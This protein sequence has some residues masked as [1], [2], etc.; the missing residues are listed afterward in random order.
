MFC[1]DTVTIFCLMLLKEDDAVAASYREMAGIYRGELKVGLKFNP[2]GAGSNANGT[3]VIDI[4]QAKSL[5]AMNANGTNSVVKLYL[6]PNRKSSGKRKTGVIKHSL[7]P[8][9]EEKFTFEDVTVDELSYAKALEVSV[10][11][12]EKISHTFIGGLRIGPAPGSGGKQYDWMDSVNDEVTHWEDMLACPGEWVEQW[13]T[14]RSTLNPRKI[15]QP[16]STPPSLAISRTPSVE[17]N[18]DEEAPLKTSAKRRD[19]I[20]FPEE[21]VSH[22]Q[23]SSL[24]GLN[25][26]GSLGSLGSMTSLYSEAGGKGNY[27]ITGEVQVGVYYKDG[28]L[29]VHVNRAEGL[30]GAKSNG[31]SD[32]Y[33]KTY[34]LPDKVKHTKKKTSVKKKT[35]DPVYDET[36]KVF[37]IRI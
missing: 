29:Y 13:H 32:P 37:C 2:S 28:E 25:R 12:N 31:F 8:V 5:P 6:L 7:N 30:A 26:P 9:W 15:Y 1:M 4:K 34:L 36:L 11:N 23:Y 18:I 24:L 14:L 33:F 3:L 19:T 35:M 17:D 20:S 21:S 10:W 27:D 22:S 16:I